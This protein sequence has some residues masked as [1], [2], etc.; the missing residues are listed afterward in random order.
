M[1]PLDQVAEAPA[2]G[3]LLAGGDAGF[4]GVGQFRVS[5]DVVGHE[6]LFDPIG[7]VF[8]EAADLVDGMAG[9]GPAVADVEHQV[10]GVAGGFAGGRDEGDVE[11][12]VAAEGSPT[13]L[14]G[15][16]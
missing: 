14:D 10:D 1:S 11:I 8:L 13:E 16:E 15:G 4:A 5:L 7:V 6:G 3:V 2:S 12:G 9:A